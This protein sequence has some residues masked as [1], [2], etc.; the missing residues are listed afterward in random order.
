MCGVVGIFNR[1]NPVDISRML[2]EACDIITHRGP[3]GS[4]SIIYDNVIGLG[5]RRLSIVDLSDRG[6]QPMAVSCPCSH[7]TYTVV[8]NG[9]IYNYKELRSELIAD[10]HSFTS[11]SDTE[12]IIHAY[13]KWGE[14]AFSRFRGMFAFALWDAR[15]RTLVCARDM[16]GIKPLYYYVDEKRFIFASE[17]K[18]LKPFGVT[19]DISLESVS[20][21]LQQGWIAQPN[22][23]YQNVVALEAGTV[24]Y[25]SE[26]SFLQKKFVSLSDIF[27]ASEYENLSYG[28]AKQKVR[29]VLSNSVAAH[30][31]AD[32]EVGAFL[33]GGIDSSSVVALM[34]ESGKK[35]ITTVSAIFPETQYD[36]SNIINQSVRAFNTRHISLP[37]N[38]NDFLSH[39]DS[40]INS[41]DQP[42]ID[43][44]N[45]YFVSLAA[46]HAG[47]RV[48]LSGL[49]GDELFYGY[50]IFKHIPFLYN[51]RFLNSLT[52]RLPPITSAF[53]K[54]AMCA[55]A[56]KGEQ[57][58]SR[59][60][61]AYRGLFSSEQVS[62]LIPILSS[63]N[64]QSRNGT[65]QLKENHDAAKRISYH[66]TTHYMK[67]QLLRD[68]DVFSMAHSLELRVPFVDSQVYDVVA[69]IPSKYKK[70]N[71]NAVK[72][73]LVDAMRDI[74]PNHLFGIK[75]QGFV[76]PIDA[77]LS[78]PAH[79][80]VVDELSRS[81]IL[82][83]KETSKILNAFAA[84]R[85]HWSRVWALFVI[86]RFFK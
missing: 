71:G 73:L 9:E 80:L 42:S 14:N 50:P 37:I 39:L 77:W 4:G 41:M 18:A 58:F 83:K 52:Q 78:G 55:R 62:T 38:G 76:L 20:S 66:E 3:D 32:V 19:Q 31:I 63:F 7:N 53:S 81:A 67:D 65:L 47:L 60:C 2:L 34:R 21:F 26:S 79:G 69:R 82:S 59:A 57:G 35:N 27:N 12:V 54:I 86:N 49:G 40:I 74:L 68:S 84:R 29:D 24:L 36:E 23:L 8:F 44:A 28:E 70:S 15:A 16:F 72:S 25:I 1:K 43:G 22:T 46:K 61:D 30:C 85:L 51:F 64:T 13:E 10:G 56:Y 6:K 48:V 45:T 11:D 75:K 17:L 5:H 33:S